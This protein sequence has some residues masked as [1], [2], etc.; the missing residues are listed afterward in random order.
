[1]LLNL[2]TATVEDGHELLYMKSVFCIVCHYNSLEISD[3][4]LIKNL[5]E[6]GKLIDDHSWNREKI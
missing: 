1:M 6:H 4:F 3:Y 5:L 2:G